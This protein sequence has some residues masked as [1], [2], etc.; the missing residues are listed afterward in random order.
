M[1]ATR[2]IACALTEL[3]RG[4]KSFDQLCTIEQQGKYLYPIDACLDARSVYESIVHADLK[5]PQEKSVVNILGQMRDI[6]QFRGYGDCG[7]LTHVTCL[8]MA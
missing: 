5:T 8:Q 1:E 7:A 2:L 4:A 6:C 3:Y